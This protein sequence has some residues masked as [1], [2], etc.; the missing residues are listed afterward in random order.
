MRL[1]DAGADIRVNLRAQW[2]QIVGVVQKER[3]RAAGN[4]GQ[5][6]A[7]RLQVDAPTTAGVLRGRERDYFTPT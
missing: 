4:R 7:G 6:Q 5:I 3:N 1:D 2:E